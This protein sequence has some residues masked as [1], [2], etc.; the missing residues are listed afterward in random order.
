ADN[1][2]IAGTLYETRL[3]TRVEGQPPVRVGEPVGRMH[4][5]GTIRR[6]GPNGELTGEV[7]QVGR[8]M[9]F[10]P[11]IRTRNGRVVGYATADG[12]SWSYDG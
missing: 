4:P 10:R 9:Q 3:E 7:L 5:D 8:D 11:E 2:P 1:R 6:I 12:Q